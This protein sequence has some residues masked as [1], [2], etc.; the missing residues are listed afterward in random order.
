MGGE[1]G[2]EWIYV[3]VW[4]NPLAVHLK[5][6]EHCQLAKAQYKVKR[7]FKERIDNTGDVYL[8]GLSELL[9]HI[10]FLCEV[11]CNI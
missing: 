9:I 2:G 4:L 3:Y 6:L 10:E 11:L 1:F 7:F 8:L 5:L